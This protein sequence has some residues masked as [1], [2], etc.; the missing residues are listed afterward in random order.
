M[1]ILIIFS[2]IKRCLKSFISK[3]KN[4]VELFKNDPKER[5]RYVF[6][7]VA[8]L[9][10]VNYLMICYHMNKNVFSFFPTIPIQESYHKIDIFVSDINGA[11]MKES[12]DV[13]EYSSNERLALFIFN[14]IVKGSHFENTSIVV[15]TKLI[16]RKVWIDNA[17]NT[18]IFDIE[19]I[20]LNDDVSVIPGSEKM[21]LDAL[22]S[23]IKANIQGIT[24]VKLLERGIPS[25][26]WEI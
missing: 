10:F 9:V 3:Y 24:K 1:N 13:V 12:R 25:G 6:L 22:T 26:I 21:F 23:S 20:I 7:S 4:A 11:I 14:E 5:K 19:P 8:F 15:P 16:V 18:C 2:S 17:S